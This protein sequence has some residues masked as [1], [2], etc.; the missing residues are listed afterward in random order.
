MRNGFF[1]IFTFMKTI[2]H[3]ILTAFQEPNGKGS[4]KR[5]S[6]FIATISLLYAVVRFTN[7][8]NVVMIVTI[9][10]GLITALAGVTAHY[11]IKAKENE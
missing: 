7:N 2:K 11:K 10:S 9:L 4:G 6:L 1:C 3:I 5:W 8:E